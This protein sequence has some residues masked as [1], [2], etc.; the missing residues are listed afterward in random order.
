ML[1]VMNDVT[2]KERWEEK[3]DDCGEVSSRGLT[4]VGI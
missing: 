4:F 3:V 1:H 2:D